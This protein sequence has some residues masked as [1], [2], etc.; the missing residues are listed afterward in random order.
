MI[1]TLAIFVS[2]H[3]VEI[4][5]NTNGIQLAFCAVD[6]LTKLGFHHKPVGVILNH[7]SWRFSSTTK[8]LNALLVATEKIEMYAKPCQV[9]F[10]PGPLVGP[11]TNS[12]QAI[13]RTLIVSGVFFD[14]E[15]FFGRDDR[16]ALTCSVHS[17]VTRTKN[18][19][20]LTWKGEMNQIWLIWNRN[21]E[22]NASGLGSALGSGLGSVLGPGSVTTS[23]TSEPWFH[24]MK[25]PIKKHYLRSVSSWVRVPGTWYGRARWG[26]NK[27]WQHNQLMESWPL[28]W[29]LIGPT[30]RHREICQLWR[31]KGK[32]VTEWG[33]EGKDSHRTI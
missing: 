6:L 17:K 14:S 18:S 10:I 5:A 15:C 21:Y 33:E 7:W 22:P 12:E 26:A 11:V 13:V 8:T 25:L 28:V 32:W 20:E 23:L 29:V 3:R 1:Y 27:C 24:E 19:R 16:A 4:K 9:I 31:G 2:L 30:I